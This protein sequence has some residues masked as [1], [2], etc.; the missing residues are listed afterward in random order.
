MTTVLGAARLCQRVTSVAMVSG[1]RVGARVGAVCDDDLY[2]C[3]QRRKQLHCTA[4]SF[5][6]SFKETSAKSM[7]SPAGI[8]LPAYMA[9]PHACEADPCPLQLSEAALAS[10][11]M[12]LPCRPAPL[13]HPA[14]A[15]KAAACQHEFAN[16]ATQARAFLL[17]MRAVWMRQQHVV[18]TPPGICKLC[19]SHV[20]Y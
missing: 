1:A 8:S 13:S 2:I 17:E 20:F 11:P 10:L 9:L 7:L 5:K 18:S 4:R 12:Q 3:M 15:D 19:C 6:V 16:A 14:R